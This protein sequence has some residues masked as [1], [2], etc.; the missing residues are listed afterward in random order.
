MKLR[1]PG[2]CAVCGIALDR[3]VR[4]YWDSHAKLVYCSAHTPEA[5]AARALRGLENVGD[6]SA[7]QADVQAGPQDLGVAG[8]SAQ[9]EH[10]RRAAARVRRVREQHPVIGGALLTIFGDPQ[11]T[12]AWANGAVGERAVGRRLD[13]LADRGVVTLHDRRVPGSSANIDHIA[14]GPSGVY[15]IDAKYRETGRVQLRRSGGLFKPELPQLWIGGRD[16]TGFIS[17]M[18][19]QVAAVTAVLG[20]PVR[21]EVRPVLALVNVDWGIFPTALEVDGVTVVWPKEAAKIAG[22]A[23]PL[24]PEQVTNIAQQLAIKL[25]PA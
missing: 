24:S 25:K 21:P 18:A 3:G 20:E 4:A 16:C 17:N 1:F 22:R 5:D 12:R 14:V 7:R 23:G 2:A 6:S 10:D 9:R 13:V 15:V 8:R 11:S 19:K